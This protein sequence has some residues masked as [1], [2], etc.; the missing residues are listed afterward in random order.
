[1]T[2]I[3]FETDRL[4]EIRAA[5]A[6]LFSHAAAEDERF[7]ETLSLDMVK[8][9]YRRNA[10]IH[11]PDM[12]RHRDVNDVTSDRFLTIRHSYEVLVRFLG[13]S[14]GIEAD[15]A[16]FRGKVIAVGG[17]KGGIGKSVITA[18]LGICLASMGLKTVLVDLD[19][20]G[21]NLHLYLGYRSILQNTIN[22]FLRKRISSLADVMIKSD[23][24]PFLIGGDSSELGS[25]NID[26]MKKMKLVKAI[27]AIE[28]DCV[29]LDLGGDTSY[30]ML[31]F[32]L[33]ADHGVVVTTRD[34]PS[35]IG[36]YHF[37]KAALYRKLNRLS[38]MESGP[39]E[40]RD[41]SLSHFIRDVTMSGNGHE[42]RTIDE[43]IAAVRTEHPGYLS[44]VMKAVWGFNPYLI[45]NR[46]PGGVGPEEVAG[47]IQIV[48]KRW[49]SREVRLLGGIGRHP[50]VEKSAIDLV[51]AITR[52]PRGVFA[53]EVAAIAKRLLSPGT[54]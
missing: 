37:L 38:G 1:M 14:A 39:A 27:R 30:N 18:N 41:P 23:H 33:Q 3:G 40:E 25:A 28:A 11:H 4:R 47:K 15:K 34:S 21:S 9:A 32:F 51:P 43:L 53:T 49:L 17:A 54:G 29:I 6:C 20:G 35:Y 46:L 36:A 8:R 45:V 19:L 2:N 13:G 7:L 16:L 52:Y 50:D 5:C 24:G 22:D 26:F 10:M 12:N 31:D 48:A 42:P 44:A